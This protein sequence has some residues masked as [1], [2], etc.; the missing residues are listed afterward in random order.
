VKLSDTRRFA[1][2]SLALRAVGACVLV[3]SLPACNEREGASTAAPPAAPAPVPAPTASTAISPAP[4][5]PLALTCQAEPRAGDV[6]LTVK[7]LAFPSGGTGVYDFNW[8]FGDGAASTQVHPT[9]TYTAAGVYSATLGV[10]SGEQVRACERTITAT[11]PVSNPGPRPGPGSPLPL[12]D[13][14]ITIVANNGGMSYSPNPAD[15]RVGQRVVWRNADVTTHTATAD[16]GAFDTGAL[17]PASSSATTM[18]AAGTFPYHCAFHPG[19]VGTLR[20][21]P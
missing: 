10:T 11:G 6:P 14:V 2:P 18:G 7:F 19:M 16:S 20:V 8:L 17:A 13:L 15:G 21:A 3:L 9:H 12:P 1:H 5:P 4:M